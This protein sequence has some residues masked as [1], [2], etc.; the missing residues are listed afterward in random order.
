MVDETDSI[1]ENAP[2]C[3]L[4]PPPPALDRRSFLFRAATT[5]L[6]ASGVFLMATLVQALMPPGRSIDG[7]TKVGRSVVGRLS[8]L[9]VGEPVMAEYGDD[10][11]FVVRVADNDVRAFDVACPHARCTLFYNEEAD[12]FDCPCHGSAFTLTGQRIEGPAPRGMVEAAT[13]VVNG[14][15]VVTGFLT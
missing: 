3:P 7:L 15:V 6:G 13:E 12:R 9:T 8:E 11:I 2:A 14:E 4:P 10:R 5:T 1:A